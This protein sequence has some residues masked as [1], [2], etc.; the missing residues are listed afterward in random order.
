MFRLLSR[1]H[2][3]H[4]QPGEAKWLAAAIVAGGI[5]GPLLLLW[6]LARLPAS[7]ASLLLNAEGVL[8]ALIA[9]FVFRENFDR[10]IAAGMALI[11]AGA[12]VLSWPGRVDR[13]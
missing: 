2:R 13:G 4:L 10:R 12:V 6:G 11:V 1:T 5:A 9:W 3:L 8:T 7:N